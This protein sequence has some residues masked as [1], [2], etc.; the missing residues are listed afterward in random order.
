MLLV[1]GDASKFAYAAYTPEGELR[2]PIY[3]TNIQCSSVILG[4]RAAAQRLTEDSEFSSTLRDNL[5]M[6]K[7]TQVILQQ[8]ASLSTRGCCIRRIARQDF[9]A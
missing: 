5:S 4:R 7:T 9:I 8:D 6:L 2:T 3:Y 1:A